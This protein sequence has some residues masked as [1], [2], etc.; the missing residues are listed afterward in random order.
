MAMIIPTKSVVRLT[1]CNG[2]STETG[3]EDLT[4]ILKFENKDNIVTKYL[5]FLFRKMLV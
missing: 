2:V 4:N 3:N 1:Y 5:H